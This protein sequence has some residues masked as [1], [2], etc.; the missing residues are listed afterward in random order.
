MPLAV[1][2]KQALVLTFTM[3]PQICLVLALSLVR[4]NAYP[5][6]YPQISEQE[7]AFADGEAD[8]NDLNARQAYSTATGS[9]NGGYAGTTGGSTYGSTGSTF[10]S[11]GT[12]GSTGTTG[13][14]TGISNIRFLLGYAPPPPSMGAPSTGSASTGYGSSSGYGSSGSTG[15]SNNQ[16]IMY[17]GLTP[18]MVVVPVQQL[19]QMFAAGAPFL[20][21]SPQSASQAAVTY[22]QNMA[23]SGYGSASSGYGSSGSTAYGK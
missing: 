3:L 21:I 22:S 12:V 11:T 17:Q 8:P 9:S 15:S 18:G 5:A 23:S 10:G 14:T 19:A 7:R 16:Y 2:R 1:L 6:F 20:A 13:T 4:I